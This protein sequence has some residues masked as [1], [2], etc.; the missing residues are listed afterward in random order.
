MPAN[1]DTSRPTESGSTEQQVSDTSEP[2]T[3]LVTATPFRPSGDVGRDFLGL[4]Q[5]HPEWLQN[6]GALTITAGLLQEE[7]AKNALTQSKLDSEIAENK[8]LTAELGRAT[9]TIATLNQEL[10]TERSSRTPR[11]VAIFIGTLLLGL[12][13]DQMLGSPS[14]ALGYLLAAGGG[15][16]IA[17]GFWWGSR[18]GRQP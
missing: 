11:A 1:E 13:I 3:A 4:V 10:Q 14:T 18:K 5:G 7:R 17:I 2:S 15:A 12:G 9:T 16:V 8:E 6:Y